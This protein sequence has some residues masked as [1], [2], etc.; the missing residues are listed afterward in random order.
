MRI[1]M[2]QIAVLLGVAVATLAA[3]AKALPEFM[4]AQQLTAWRAQH[5]APTA[6][7]APTTDE[8]TQFF[9]GKPYDAASGTYLFKYRAYNPSLAR[10]TS[11]D[12]RGFP[13]GSNN[14]LLCDNNPVY[15]I[16]RFG[17]DRL[18]I[19]AVPA[20]GSSGGSGS[21][22]GG[23]GHSWITLEDGQGNQTSYGFWPGDGG[24]TPLGS[25]S[26]QQYTGLVISDT[27]IT[28]GGESPRGSY[29]VN[30]SSEQNA[31]LMDGVACFEST[32]PTWS[33]SFNC[34]DF[35]AMVASWADID[36]G[37]VK[38]HGYSDPDKLLKW[39]NRMNLQNE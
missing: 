4:N 5:S 19:N 25:L 1:R 24:A 15:F 30:I 26:G 13:D 29:A 32:N 36:V 37:D 3:Q 31:L 16:D 14:Q 9:T 8:Q 10:W 23:W 22:S 27:G 17:L 28:N 6:A 18:I 20:G 2:L 11:A 38:T 34:T 12:P 7:V 21:G 35:A 39:I 33:L